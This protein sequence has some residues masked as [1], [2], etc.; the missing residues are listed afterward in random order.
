M[1]NLVGIF[2][3]VMIKSYTPVMFFT[4]NCT[5]NRTLI[6]DV[7]FEDFLRIV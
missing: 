6:A 4:H 7:I 5:C 2:H 3:F 1:G